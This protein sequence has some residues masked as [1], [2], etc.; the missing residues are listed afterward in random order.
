MS[1]QAG[2]RYRRL[3]LSPAD[4]SEHEPRS[5]IVAS[6]RAAETPDWEIEGGDASLLHVTRED[7]K[8]PRVLQITGGKSVRL[9][10]PGPFE[11]EAFN[12]VAVTMI[13]P[14]P[15]QGV[16]V[17]TI[18]EGAGHRTPVRLLTENHALV[19]VRFDIETPRSADLAV[20]EWIAVAAE[21]P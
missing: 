18:R 3:V 15:R 4:A 11:A 13:S 21:I 7:P 8:S 6:F 2:S 12:Q 20:D 1:A 19:T 5:Q 9:V 10:V 16:R 17:E 14:E